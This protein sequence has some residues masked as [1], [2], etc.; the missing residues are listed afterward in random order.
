MKWFALAMTVLLVACSNKSIYKGM[1]E[2]NRQECNKLPDSQW[3]QCLKDN[4]QSYEDYKRERD[5]LKSSAE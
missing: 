4:S 2:S 3:E 5:A 1:Q